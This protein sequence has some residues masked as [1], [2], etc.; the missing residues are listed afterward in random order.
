MKMPLVKRTPAGRIAIKVYDYQRLP[1]FFFIQE[2]LE[3]S[4]IIERSKF[5]RISNTHDI[6]DQ[7][8][9]STIFEFRNRQNWSPSNTIYKRFTLKKSEALA[10][11]AVLAKCSDDVFLVNLKSEILRAL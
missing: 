8:V 11:V 3:E 10:L 6:K 5:N 2:F 7:L 4:K 1:L 9:L